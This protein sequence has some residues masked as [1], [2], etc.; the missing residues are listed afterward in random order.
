MEVEEQQA[1]HNMTESI[2]PNNQS[3][4]HLQSKIS[5]TQKRSFYSSQF[6]VSM[7]LSGI[8]VPDDFANDK[9]AK[10]NEE[11]R[12]NQLMVFDEEEKLIHLERE[13]KLNLED[14]IQNK[15]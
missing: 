11:I 12:R 7:Q 4:Q 10:L 3:P 9:I 14:V 8:N 13:I 2:D 15:N 1:E 6:P 5:N